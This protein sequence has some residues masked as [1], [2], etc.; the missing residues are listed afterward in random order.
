M[1]AP[2][3]AF[4]T[5]F[6]RFYGHPKFAL[7]ALA[8]TALAR[9]TPGLYDIDPLDPYAPKPSIT[10]II[11]MMNKS[12]LPPFYAKLVAEYAIDNLDSLAGTVKRFGPAVAVGM[13]KAVPNQP[14]P[15]TQVG[16]EVHAAI[17]RHS[18]G[19]E[20]EVPFSTITA[21]RMFAQYCYFVTQYPMEVVRSEY[22]VWSYEYG[23]AGTG[24]L[25]VETNFG[26]AIW[27]AK[28]GNN[29]WPEVALQTSAIAH[30][31]VILDAQ[32]NELPMPVAALQGVLH[33]R[34][35]SVKLHRL[36]RTN[37][38]FETFLACKRI[39]DWKRFDC[40]LV[41]QPPFKTEKP[42]GIAA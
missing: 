24:D 11:G 2:Q 36:E 20:P 25:L 18:Q 41:M 33:V 29:A 37:E 8:R 40:D 12:F 28:T 15:A 16:N 35:M 30:A 17:D 34:P 19:L 39:F 1:T 9:G 22:T 3:N 26:L 31:D 42:K 4:Q 7:E 6:G 10:N 23:F 38:A 32:G 13:L 27:D 21:A 5:N 14:N